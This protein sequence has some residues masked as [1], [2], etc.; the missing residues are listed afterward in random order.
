MRPY[1][2]GIPLVWTW[3]SSTA[4]IGGL[5]S[6]MWPPIWMTADVPSSTTSFVKGAPPLMF[7]VQLLPST[8]GVTA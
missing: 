7:E 3:N 5:D 4:S 8:L 2:A 6:P 1:S